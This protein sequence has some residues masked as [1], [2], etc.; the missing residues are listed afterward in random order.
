MRNKGGV[1]NG[2]GYDAVDVKIEE[3]RKRAQIEGKTQWNASIKEERTCPRAHERS[4]TAVEE[5][6]QNIASSA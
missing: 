6:G 3:E 4:T 2:H 5:D 1:G